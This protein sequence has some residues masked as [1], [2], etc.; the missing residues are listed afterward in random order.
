MPQRLPAYDAIGSGELALALLLVNA[1]VIGAMAYDKLAARKGGWRIPEAN[2]LL[3]AL[4][5]G[6]PALWASMKWFRH[7][8]VKQ[9]FRL[10]F[11]AVVAVQLLLIGLFIFK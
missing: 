8:T 9:S 7:K 4:L 1:L 11:F 5:G 2:L 3:L 6:S 10:K